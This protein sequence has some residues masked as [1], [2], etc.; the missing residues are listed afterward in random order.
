MTKRFKQKTILFKQPP[1]KKQDQLLCT[2]IKWLDL[3]SLGEC[4]SMVKD[5]NISRFIIFQN[6]ECQNNQIQ[7][8]EF[9][10]LAR[11]ENDTLIKIVYQLCQSYLVG[12]VDT[13][14]FQIR[15]LLNF[16]FKMNHL[17]QWHSLQLI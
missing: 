14:S 1:L 5:Y 4:I 10:Q 16:S 8:V 13:L 7:S 12:Q 15:I 6:I 9:E 3:I 11:Q 2:F 17:N